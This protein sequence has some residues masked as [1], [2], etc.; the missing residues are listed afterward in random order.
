MPHQQSRRMGGGLKEAASHQAQGRRH[1]GADI[2]GRLE[3]SVQILRAGKYSFFVVWESR[4]Q[5]ILGAIRFYCANTVKMINEL[6]EMGRLHFFKSRFYVAFKQF[7]LVMKCKRTT[8]IWPFFI[9]IHCY[10]LATPAY[11]AFTTAR[12]SSQVFL[13]HNTMMLNLSTSEGGRTLPAHLSLKCVCCRGLNIL[14]LGTM[15]LV[16]YRSH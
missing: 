4:I 3:C 5:N 6:C 1:W 12:C 16:F 8:A 15:L 7:V 13:L 2:E 14:R 11:A 9:I 10:I